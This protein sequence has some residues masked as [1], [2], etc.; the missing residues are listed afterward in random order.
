MSIDLTATLEMDKNLCEVAL[1]VDFLLA[2]TPVDV[3]QAWKRFH[4]GGYRTPPTFDYRAVSPELP[5]WR[6]RLDDLTPGAIEDPLLASMLEHKQREVQTQLD[7]LEFRNTPRF[8]D[9]SL[10]LYGGVDSALAELALLILEA[11]VGARTTPAANG[12][13]RQG[14]RAFA[15]RAGLELQHYRAVYPALESK[16]LVLDEIPGIMAFEGDLLIG[17]HLSLPASRVEALIQHEVGTHLVTF[18]NGGVHRLKMLQL[19]LAG[20]EETQEA[21]AVF[22]EYAV[23]GLT[24]ARLAQLAARVVAVDG[25]LQG[26]PFT[27][28]F[29]LLTRRHR[30]PPRA[31]FQVVARVFR[32]GGL[33]K[34]AIYL[35]GIAGLLAYLAG[36]GE[37]EP[38]FAGKLP[39]GSVSLLPHLERLGLVQAPPLRP[40]W[41]DAPEAQ[42]RIEAAR[43]GMSVVDLIEEDAT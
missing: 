16:V 21:L 31:A 23:G 11:S 7:C 42:P 3:P 41:A 19:G 9:A 10:R 25:L 29:K 37:L 33:T 20:Y 36:G 28:V 14:S 26:A 27:E 22:A 17:R 35:R 24:R 12:E 6:S 8:L 38:L 2:V 40:R 15:R 18:A 39:V 13:R 34:D 32:S 30:M 4:A 5:R 43:R 1:C